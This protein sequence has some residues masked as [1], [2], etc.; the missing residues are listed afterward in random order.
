MAQYFIGIDGGS[1]QT[2]GV[3]LDE[4]QR[5]LAREAT[6]PTNYHTVGLTRTEENLVELINRL[7]EK[8]KT[9]TA[10][11]ARFCLALSGVSREADRRAISGLLHRHSLLNRATLISDAEAVLAATEAEAP[12]IVAVAGTGSIVLAR[13]EHGALHQVGGH[14]RLLDDNGS[15]YDIGLSG[16]RAVLEADDGRGPKTALTETLLAAAGLS[17]LDEIVPWLY[18]STEQKSAVAR[19]AP[20]VIETAAK[21][22]APAIAIL[23]RAAGDLARWVAVASGAMATTDQPVTI[24]LAGGVLEHSEFYRRLASERVL[25]QLPHAHIVAPERE[26]AHGAALL[27]LGAR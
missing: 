4:T 13:D 26:A 21:G 3:I 23:E 25:A 17:N 14:G 9:T 10:D 5:L 16:L 15:A 20:T 11:V 27:A 18:G 1:S 7:A 8:A 2:V 19:L 22:D 6:G 24:V 12:V